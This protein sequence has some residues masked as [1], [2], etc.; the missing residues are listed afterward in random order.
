MLKYDTFNQNPY[1]VHQKIIQF[2]GE[3]KKVLDVGC[4]GGHISKKLYTNKCD[5]IGIELDKNSSLEAQNYCEEIIIGDVESIELKDKYINYFDFIIFADVLEHLKNPSE[6]INHFS[7]YLID[8]GYII[9]SLP[10]IANWRIRF[11]LL[12]GN[13][14]YESYGILDE[15]HLRFFTEKTA[16]K[17]IR[18]A[19]LEI[20]E[21]DVT[22]GDVNKLAGLF[23]SFGLMWPNL[24]AFQFL[25]IARKSY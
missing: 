8:K 1:S 25:I 21:F 16:K 18:D 7:K 15:G 5:V 6:V 9:I 12:M 20:Y 10:N 19:G 22:I 2:V 13:F 17:L 23:H 3:K 24:L 4:A 14:D 11:N